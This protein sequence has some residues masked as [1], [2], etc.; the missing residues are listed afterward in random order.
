MQVGELVTRIITTYDGSGLNNFNTELLRGVKN[1]ESAQRQIVAL[2]AA[3]GKMRS[4]TD[5]GTRALGYTLSVL[6]QLGPNIDKVVQGFSLFGTVLGTVGRGVTTVF[7]GLLGTIERLA[8]PLT[9]T[10]RNVLNLLNP[11]NAVHSAIN[12]IGRVGEIALGVTLFNAIAQL[13]SEAT[14]FVTALAPLSTGIFAGEIGTQLKALAVTA[15]NA[16]FSFEQVKG[17]VA[18]VRILGIEAS[19]AIKAITQGFQVGL[20]P[21]QIQQLA[22]AAQDMAVVIGTNSSEAFNR[23]FA[24]IST[25][26]T[27]LLRFAGIMKTQDQLIEDFSRSSGKSVQEIR[28]NINL[29]RQA[30][31]QGILNEAKQFA[32]AYESSLE[33][34][35]KKLSS[36]PRQFNDLRLGIGR[37]F[38]PFL[39]G[40]FTVVEEM[41]ESLSRLF[42]TT[43]KGAYEAAAAQVSQS[44]GFKLTAKD[45]SDLVLATI[46]GGEEQEKAFARISAS[47][48]ASVESL[49]QLASQGLFTTDAIAKIGHAFE[50]TVLGSQFRALAYAVGSIV[51]GL[52]KSFFSIVNGGQQ[53][54]QDGVPG[55]IQAGIKTVAGFATGILTGITQFVVPGIISILTA[56][57][58]ILAGGTAALAQSGLSMAASLVSGLVSGLAAGLS[59]VAGV[60]TNLF[61]TLLSGFANGALFL[62]DV[63]NWGKDIP[64]AASEGVKEGEF[65]LTQVLQD[66][67]DAALRQFAPDVGA[68][69][70]IG[71]WGR[72][73][74]RAVLESLKARDF[75]ALSFLEG[76]IR[77]IFGQGAEEQAVAA[78]NAVAQALADLNA[79]GQ[80]S[81]A[82][83]ASLASSFGAAFGDVQKYL[84]AVNQMNIGLDKQEQLENDLE[85]ATDAV[86]AAQERLRQFEADSAGIPERYTRGRRAQLQAEL[87]AAQKE[88]EKRRDALRDQ[89]KA[90]EKIREQVELTRSLLTELVR[91]AELQAKIAQDKANERPETDQ[92]PIDD[93]DAQLKRIAN[94]FRAQIID[95]FAPV[96]EQFLVLGNILRGLLGLD[97]QLPE[98][99]DPADFYQDPEGLA[100]AQKAYDRQVQALQAAHGK[101]VTLRDTITNLAAVVVPKLEAAFQTVKDV[102]SD[103]YDLFLK[104]VPVVQGLV[105]ALTGQP[106]PQS[107]ATDTS[108]GGQRDPKATESAGGLGGFKAGQEL[109]VISQKTIDAINAVVT[110]IGQ[111]TAFAAAH[112]DGVKFVAEFGLLNFLSGGALL[113][114]L[115]AQ[116]P[117]IIPAAAGIISATFQSIM[118]AVDVIGIVGGSIMSGLFAALTAPAT[119]LALGGAFIGGLVYNMIATITGGPS[120]QTMVDQL[121]FIIK[122]KGLEGLKAVGREF[123]V[124][125]ITAVFNALA[126]IQEVSATLVGTILGAIAQVFGGES[127]A[128]EVRQAVESI[129]AAVRAPFEALYDFLVGHSLIPD[130][131]DAIVSIMAGAAGRLAEPMANLSAAILGPIQSAAEAAQGL[132]A[133]ITGQ[134]PAESNS[135]PAPQ[136][137]GGAK[138]NDVGQSAAPDPQ[139]ITNA[140]K[141]INNALAQAGTAE[142]TEKNV[143]GPVKA[144]FSDMKKKVADEDVPEMAGKV[145][146]SVTDLAGAVVAP[147]RNVANNIAAPIN[148]LQG[149]VRTPLQNAAN[150]V[151]SKINDML[152]PT[153]NFKQAFVELGGAAETQMGKVK[154]AVNGLLTGLK[155]SFRELR[156]QL[157]GM[158]EDINKAFKELG[159]GPVLEA[160]NQMTSTMLRLF[161]ELF[162]EL[163]G[164][165]IVPDLVDGI[166]GEFQDLDPRT[167]S[168]LAKFTEGVENTIGD[169]DGKFSNVGQM[170]LPSGSGGKGGALDITVNQNGWV[171]P[172]NMDAR[173]QELLRKIARDEAY[174]GITIAFTKAAGAGA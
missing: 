105:A 64:G 59:T 114:L 61:T 78:S 145:T 27:Q 170:R 45:L 129:T 149:R 93:I 166:V 41:T 161:R 153:R 91:A 116:L 100:E 113:G 94:N 9:N 37:I 126:G 122:T 119:L 163:V 49:K 23:L 128:R 82:T 77:N 32:G 68:T 34:L 103:I 147:A 144:H 66:L 5:V 143:T 137:Q 22:R 35:G 164:H 99:P 15:A 13:T 140:I 67:R 83:L 57:T 136:S 174:A 115:A 17:S 36:F 73:I 84:E 4:S 10:I 142:T 141:Q 148:E 43:K 12:T 155:T 80:I 160:I 123:M 47:S 92:L 110:L 162:D 88:Q 40:A 48:G 44:T 146:K 121:M 71:N 18:G 81:A 159:K 112:P 1:A 52:A 50:P 3:L 154:T 79:T 56:I 72:G 117:A 29:L 98:P 19:E 90:N 6:G 95:A 74:V 75:S 11:L 55:F 26:N 139:A 171:F 107:G 109:I 124:G 96:R 118:L 25:G 14:R 54:I 89:Q 101:G 158:V 157:V 102:V 31:F 131:V 132:I 42:F 104:M 130:L 16:G 165:S 106:L 127:A 21:S 151:V 108:Q 70:I 46:K 111:I 134:A 172:A 167:K 39:S 7:G 168:P 33:E 65:N 156:T 152:T 120:I 86:Q 2:D 138:T 58:Q 20:N 63:K 133:Q 97:T 60:I 8:S 53:A 173:Q 87:D 85:D 62:G 28:G 30:F 38:E 125:L 76:I 150:E 51:S 169:I 69:D 135:S 24:A